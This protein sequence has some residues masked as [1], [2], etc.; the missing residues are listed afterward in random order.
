MKFPPVAS[1]STI[2]PSRAKY[3]LVACTQIPIFGTLRSAFP[4][5]SLVYRRQDGQII[6]GFLNFYKKGGWLPTWPNPG[7]FNCMV[8]ADADA[9]VASAY[10][11][12]IGV[13][14][15][16]WRMP[17]FGRTAPCSRA[18]Q[19]MVSPI[20]NIICVWVMQWRILERLGELAINPRRIRVGVYR[21]VYEIHDRE[22]TICVLAIGHRREVYRRF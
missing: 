14:I 17:P 22:I 4:L 9:V 8:G 19:G 16:R 7:Y 20:L 5:L 15:R 13:L 11:R 12:G 10:L 3:I 18:V 2:V 21:L 1:A 6:R